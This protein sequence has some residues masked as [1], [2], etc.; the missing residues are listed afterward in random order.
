MNQAEGSTVAAGKMSAEPL[1]GKLARYSVA[2]RAFPL[3][4]QVHLV[5]EKG[6][7]GEFV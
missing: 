3:P 6:F 1:E 5:H 7:D 4:P 2:R